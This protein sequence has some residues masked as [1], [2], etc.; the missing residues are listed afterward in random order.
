M[1]K[2]PNALTVLTQEYL[3]VVYSFELIWKVMFE[4]NCKIKCS[5]GIRLNPV[6]HSDL[7]LNSGVFTYN[8]FIV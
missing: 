4:L 1:N 3:F 8:L 7:L 2:Y 6:V 5:S